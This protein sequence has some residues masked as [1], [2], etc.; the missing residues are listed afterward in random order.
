[1]KTL[2]KIGGFNLF[3]LVVF[4]NWFEAGTKMEYKADVLIE[5]P[6][7]VEAYGDAVD[8]CVRSGWLKKPRIGHAVLLTPWIRYVTGAW[9][10]LLGGDRTK[11]SFLDDMG[12][13]TFPSLHRR[14]LSLLGEFMME[15]LGVGYFYYRK[16]DGVIWKICEV[17]ECARDGG[18]MAL[19]IFFERDFG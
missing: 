2:F 3:T 10:S 15:G 1:V 8:A 4:R 9:S 14:I 13:V 6:A 18:I 12:G 16:S 11:L 7:V 17:R 5:T 19:E